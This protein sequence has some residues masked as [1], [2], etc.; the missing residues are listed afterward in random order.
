M[1]TA[2]ILLTAAFITFVYWLFRKKAHAATPAADTDFLLTAD[3]S[4]NKFTIKHPE[5][6]T[7]VIVNPEEATLG[8]ANHLNNTSHGDLYWN[9]VPGNK[10][11]ITLFYEEGAVLSEAYII[12]LTTKEAIY[13]KQLREATVTA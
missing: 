11:V 6:G 1:K 8:E 7:H 10:F 9:L 13:H 5:M 3:W 2:H 4:A 12:D